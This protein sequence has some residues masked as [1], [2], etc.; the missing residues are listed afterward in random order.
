MPQ[1]EKR[2]S[3]VQSTVASSRLPVKL[4]WLAAFAVC[5]YLILNWA[6]VWP[7]AIFFSRGGTRLFAIGFYFAMYAAGGVSLALLLA[8]LQRHVAALALIATIITVCTNHA[9]ARIFGVRP[10]DYGM[11]QWLFGEMPELWG[12]LQEF[13][14]SISWALG[15]SIA[16]IIPLAIV[17]ALSRKPMRRALS[18]PALFLVGVITFGTYLA[19]AFLLDRFFDDGAPLDSNLYVYYL[20]QFIDEPP[21]RIAA[22]DLPVPSV[23]QIRKLILVV[24]ESVNYAIYDSELRSAW[25]DYLTAD[26]GEAASTGNCSA[27]SNAMLRWG[28]RADAILRGDDP[29]AAPTVWGYARAAG[30]TTVLIDG[31]RHGAY[32]NFMRSEEAALI[33]KTYAVSEGYDTDHAIAMV[34]HGLLESPQ[35]MFIYINK[36]GAHF[37]YSNHYPAGAAAANETRAEQ[38]RA[39]VRYSS[40]TFLPTMLAGLDLSRVLVVYTSDHGQNLAADTRHGESLH[41]SQ[42]PRWQELSVPLAVAT[43]AR[44]FAAEL[45]AAAQRNRDRDRHAQIFP[46]LLTAMGYDEPS[47]EKLYGESLM[48]PNPPTQY[49]YVGNRPIALKGHSPAAVA[50]DRFPFRP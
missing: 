9:V 19:S 1:H 30:Y 2:K 41:C 45:Q 20:R 39:A 35:P 8:A 15:V 48:A 10:L 34:V 4:L 3:K 14:V 38:Y 40:A 46:T 13:F 42:K 25:A 12:A 27:A 31:Q 23:P 44:G 22:V 5:A 16:S 36:R 28:L 33:S 43:T 24:D 6:I 49:I 29:R 17:T 37:P 26:F 47:V 18:S 21:P 50:F 32:Q 7:R 11:A